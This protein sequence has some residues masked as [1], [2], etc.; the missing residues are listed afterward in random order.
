MLN[1]LRMII[2]QNVK[3]MYANPSLFCI[4]NSSLCVQEETL[5]CMQMQKKIV[6]ISFVDGNRCV[7]SHVMLRTQWKSICIFAIACGVHRRKTFHAN[8]SVDACALHVNTNGTTKKLSIRNH[9]CF[10]ADVFCTHKECAENKTECT[11]IHLTCVHNNLRICSLVC[12]RRTIQDDLFK[13]QKH[14][15]NCFLCSAQ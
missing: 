15:T 11:Q 9:I 10:M 4:C 8:V 1:H 3:P 13:M 12:V 7:C 2:V 6:S 5:T 14:C